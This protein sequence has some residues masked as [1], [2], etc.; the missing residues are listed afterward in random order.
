MIKVKNI[1]QQAVFLVTNIN[2]P[3]LSDTTLTNAY[4]YKIFKEL[5][6]NNC[7]HSHFCLK[8]PVL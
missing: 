8:V 4:N 7:Q 2:L 3:V 1:K 6:E 5:Y